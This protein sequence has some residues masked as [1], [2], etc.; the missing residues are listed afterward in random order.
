MIETIIKHHRHYWEDADHL[1]KL[2]REY[3]ARSTE[4]GDPAQKEYFLYWK[5]RL[6]RMSFIA[7]MM[8]VEALLNN[9][10][11]QYGLQDKFKILEQLAKQFP[12]QERFP[13][14]RRK[15]VRRPYQVPLKWKLY[16][17]PYL[18]DTDSRMDRDEY[19]QYETGSYRKFRRLIMVRNE[20]VHTRVAERDIDI[21]MRTNSPQ[22]IHEADGPL[23]IGPEYSECCEEL[24]IDKD[25]LCFKIDNAL[26][27]TQAMKQVVVDL[28]NFLGGRIL[29]PDFWDSAQTDFFV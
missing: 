5:Y 21:V 8:A 1:I 2:A 29:S 4:Q 17:T 9:A 7:R 13:S 28:N 15:R 14:N 23:A 16:L 18:C 26:V 19:F 10:L 20:F 27:C 11:E 22:P 24:G 12:R 6:A 3:Q 25:P